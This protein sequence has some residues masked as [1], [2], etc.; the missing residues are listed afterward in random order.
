MHVIGLV[1]GIAS[2][3]STVAAELAKLGAVALDA[4]RAAH[5]ALDLPE[6]Q[7]KL[8]ERW[9]KEILAESGKTDRQAVAERVFNPTKIGNPELGF[10]ERQIHPGIRQ[11]FEKQLADLAKQGQKFA[12]VD[13]PLL[14]EAGWGDMCDSIVYIESSEA[15]RTA[16]INPRNWSSDEI[17]RREQ[18]Q[19][20]IDEK[21]R[22][23]THTIRNLGSPE[24]LRAEVRSFWEAISPRRG[25]L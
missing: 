10:L 11:L 24:Q 2:G 18:A 8:V 25:K 23:S 7:Q 20:P 17:S 21:K 15:D 1:G 6:V 12:V 22:Q 4:D 3:K 16:R 19:M 13:A 14:L 9:G 5:V